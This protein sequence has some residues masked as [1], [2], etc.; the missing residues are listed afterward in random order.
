[1]SVG[2]PLV[3]NQQPPPNLSDTECRYEISGLRGNMWHS[4]PPHTARKVAGA[5]TKS[6]KA[7]AA[8][9]VASESAVVKRERRAGRARRVAEKTALAWERVRWKNFQLRNGSYPSKQNQSKRCRNLVLS[10]LRNPVKPSFS[11]RRKI[12]NFVPPPSATEAAAAAAKAGAGGG[13]HFGA[14]GE[15]R[16]DVGVD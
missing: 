2:D 9:R 5:R 6:L 11:C 16:V 14:G 15:A 1:M 3:G 13:R 12:W 4:P 7:V 8:R 10:Y